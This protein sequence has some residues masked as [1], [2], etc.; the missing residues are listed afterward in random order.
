M[1]REASNALLFEL[2]DSRCALRWRFVCDGKLCQLVD[3]MIRRWL[4]QLRLDAFN[5]RSR[6]VDFLAM[7]GSSDMNFK[8]ASGLNDI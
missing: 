5:C 1:S 4:F 8:R 7:L 3:V 2:K 6:F